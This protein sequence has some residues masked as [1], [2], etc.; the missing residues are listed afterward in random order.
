MIICGVVSI[1]STGQ[2]IISHYWRNYFMHGHG[3]LRNVYRGKLGWEW[4]IQSNSGTEL[5]SLPYLGSL[6]TIPPPHTH[7]HWLYCTHEICQCFP[8]R[9][10]KTMVTHTHIHTYCPDYTALASHVSVLHEGEQKQITCTPGGVPYFEGHTWFW[11]QRNHCDFCRDF[12]ILLWFHDFICDFVI[13]VYLLFYTLFLAPWI[14]LERK[15]LPS[16]HEVNSF[17]FDMGA[18]SEVFLLH[19]LLYVMLAVYII[20]CVCILRKYTK[21]YKFCS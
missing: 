9:G 2:D 20:L 1:S 5:G 13:S 18:F 21:F 19:R 4:I 11:N 10:A 8:C 7:T 3:A 6:K 16:W 12:M 17:S 14:R 15:S